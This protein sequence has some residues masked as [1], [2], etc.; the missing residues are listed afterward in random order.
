MPVE[1][2][3]NREYQADKPSEIKLKIFSDDSMVHWEKDQSVFTLKPVPR[4]ITL[5]PVNN[6]WRVSVL[7]L[8]QAPPFDLLLKADGNLISQDE[9]K[10]WSI[11][12]N[13]SG[14]IELDIKPDN[15]RSL[16]HLQP[17]P[18]KCSACWTS[19][20]NLQV[21]LNA[22]SPFPSET[23]RNIVSLNIEDA[24]FWKRCRNLI[25]TIFF[26]LLFLWWL[27]GIIRKPR[28]AKGKRDYISAEAE[29][30]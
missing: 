19:S 16:F 9:I 6:Q 3:R 13:T 27:I 15:A 21:E 29:S 2:L 10:A 7:D 11:Q 18:Y 17:R 23:C 25:L 30:Y 26:I 12:Y 1:I 5:E 24:P 8:K 4:N 14:R 20:G 28:F 22:K